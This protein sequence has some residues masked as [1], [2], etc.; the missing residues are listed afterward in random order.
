MYSSFAQTADFTAD[1]TGGCSPLDIRFTNKSSGFSAGATYSWD[2]GNGNSSTL[3]SPGT[4]YKDEKVYTVKLSV[5]DGGKTYTK[6]M[7]V[8]VY[9]KPQVSFSAD[10]S[11]GCLPLP[12]TFTST[13]T[14]GDGTISN[15]FWDFGDGSTEANG[16]QTQQHTFNSA[17]TVTA[18]LTV[19]NNYGCFN[20]FT[21]KAIVQ[22]LP[23]VKANFSAPQ[24]VLCRVTDAATFVNTSTGSGTL[25]YAWDFGDGK[26][27]KDKNPSHVYNSKG[28]YT[29]KLTVTSSDGC[30]A[31]T[32]QN[33]FI[34]VA[35]FNIDFD[36][37]SLICQNNN[38]TFVDK[39][40]PITNTPLWLIDGIAYG[41][42]SS[43]FSTIFNDGKSHKIQLVNNFG[44][45]LDTATKTITAKPSPKLDGFIIDMQGACGAPSTVK[46]KDTTATAV[47]WAWDF[48]DSYGGF[49]PTAFDQ[50]TTFTYTSDRTYY[51][52]LQVTNAD[53]CTATVSKVLAVYKTNAV[54][55]S[56]S[57]SIGCLSMTSV[58]TATSDIEIKEYKWSFSDGGT[59]TSS[60]PTHTFGKPGN[61]TVTLNYTNANGCKGSAL[62]YVSV[63]EKPSFDFTASPGTTIC[64][65]TPVVFSVTGTNLTGTYYWNF[66]DYN[67][68]SYTINNTHQYYYDSVYTV[69]LVIQNQGCTDTVTKKNYITV[70]PPFP[71]ISSAL[72]TCDGTRGTVTFT[73]ASQKAKGWSWDFGDGSAAQ[74]YNTVKSEIKHTYTKTGTYQVKLTA[75]NGSCSVNDS[76]TVYVLLKQKPLLTAASTQV[77][78]NDELQLTISKMEVNPY[79]TYYNY[80]Q[81]GIFKKLYGDGSEFTGYTYSSD[82]DWSSVYHFSLKGLDASKKDLQIV[83][84]SYYFNCYDTTNIVPL[85]IKGPIAGF[86]IDKNDICFKSPAEF[87]DTSKGTNNVPIQKWEWNY[88]DGVIEALTKGGL[89]TH[90]YDNPGSYPVTLTVTDKDGCTAS[91][92]NYSYINLKGPKAAFNMSANPVL[93][94]TTVYFY[95]NSNLNG[96]DYYNDKF[97][98]LYGD[99]TSSNNS[100]YETVYHTYPQTGIDT[101][102]LIASSSDNT[103]VDTA[104]QYLR[105]KNINL[106]YSYTT[107]YINPSSGCPPVLA[108][109]VNNSINTNHISWDFGDGGTA[110]NLNYA[111]HTYK[112]PG[113]YKV[114][115]YGYF[116][117]GSI[118]STFDYITI[119]GPYATLKADKLFSCGA[120]AI[121]LSAE[122]NNTSSFTWDFGDGTL[123]DVKDTF[124]VHRYLTPGV[125][126]PSLI[127]KDGS[128]CSFP[129]FLDDKIVIDTLHITIN[130]QPAIVCDSANVFFSEDM[131]SVAKNQ[132]Q[133]TMQYHWNFGT[134]N[135]KDTSA[136]DAPSFV[137]NNVGTYPVS[138]K[139]VSPYGC[140]DETKI[141]VLVKPT[142]RGK[143]TGPSQICEDA[144]GTFTATS[145]I[146]A[147]NL[148]WEWHFQNNA[149]SSQQNPSLQQFTNPGNDSVT[150]IINNDGCYDTTYHSIIVHAKPVINITPQQP[151][152]CVGDSIQLQ[153]HDGEVYKWKNNNYIDNPDINNPIVFPLI[154]TVYS[155]DVTNNFGCIN[156][157]SVM[158]LVTQRFK[159][160]ADSPVHLCKGSSVELKAS[161]A[162]K[163]VWIDGTDLS[164]TQIANPVTATAT[165]RYY[166]VV[167][168]DNYGC[169][170]DT[171][172]TEVKIDPLPTVNA[173]PDIT[174]FAGS[175]VQLNTTNSSDVIAWKWEP[176]TYLNCS[177]C[178]SPKSTPRSDITYV[179]EVSTDHHCTAK[180]SINIH[181]ICKASL[182]QIPSSFTPNG[183]LLNDYFKING[184]GIKLI[185]HFIIFGRWGEKVF[186]KNNVNANDLGAAWNGTYQNRPLQAGTFVYMAEVICDTGEAFSFKGTVTLIR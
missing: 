138:L 101:V 184:Q 10:V 86:T 3:T 183:D 159:T 113:V 111:S 42:Q 170:S 31:Q 117:D 94:N 118:D 99:G 157:D 160:I 172:K 140:V 133:Q 115:L 147:S 32:T 93:P 161:G 163:Y 151:H 173:G 146:T 148:I 128:G 100:F 180:D 79:F 116:D 162:D 24:T 8:T 168:Y 132:L 107:T 120:K 127:V 175:E 59:S 124:A 103:C 104:I 130:K 90:R 47:K 74:S 33:A 109:F 98:W 49:N 11:K 69:S 34:N 186:E 57:G 165:P 54:I 19:T 145:D 16:Q 48:D 84:Q 164:N 131:I 81:Y 14:A 141:D 76:M 152:V 153:A 96:T 125:Y 38:V 22:V 17:Q 60:K 87:K 70:L 83:T 51:P 18:S 73:E 46:F 126:T 82:Y 68:Y 50:S 92:Q 166:T 102:T 53:G 119:K 142:A 44:G 123:L 80:Y 9:K 174:T 149:T 143:I 2:F 27:S 139:V 110:D 106:A 45:C 35:N 89:T 12:V 78:E 26:T 13:S 185:K 37:P 122:A 4:T 155:V 64:G 135:L 179:V 39:S 41:Y 63:Y 97:T 129:F 28:A 21:N 112:L 7:N 95:N 61:Y 55:S 77:C 30:T 154:S 181:I 72:N 25:S 5:T 75:T 169:F 121:T 88:G 1:K 156:S 171:A 91:A 136:L 65:N 56:S 137:Y 177:N 158:V 134:G 71:K 20:T 43:Q 85:T 144:Y 40:T 15:Y 178:A 6:T 176:S 29:V 167:G 182:V 105:V 108:S 52:T 66:G 150:L 58:F 114:T 36:A 23:A 62:Y 67:Y